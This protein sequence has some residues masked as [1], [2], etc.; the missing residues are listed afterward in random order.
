MKG[1][2]GRTGEEGQEKGKGNHEEENISEVCE[3]KEWKK[4]E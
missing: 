1:K 3:R 2:T 4:K